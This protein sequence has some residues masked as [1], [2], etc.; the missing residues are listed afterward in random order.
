[1]IERDREVVFL[2]SENVGSVVTPLASVGAR[3]A[4]GE[5]YDVH[6]VRHPDPSRLDGLDPHPAFY[7]R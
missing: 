1:M 4:A 3:V 2:G 7:G 5:T 6:I